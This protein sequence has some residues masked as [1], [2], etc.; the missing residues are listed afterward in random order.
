MNM[1]TS[2]CKVLPIAAKKDEIIEAVKN[3]TYTIISAEPANSNT[4]TAIQHLFMKEIN[5]LYGESK[6]SHLLGSKKKILTPRE[7]KHK[8]DFDSFVKE[9]MP[10][11]SVENISERLELLAEF[12]QELMEADY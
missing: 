3:H 1:Q 12:Y 6:F 10:D 5:S 7:V 2:A 9:C 11:L 8:E 4:L